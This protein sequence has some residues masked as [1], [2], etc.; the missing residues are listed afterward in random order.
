M[1]PVA[2]QQQ[3]QQHQQHQQHPGTRGHPRP[4][5]VTP[6]GQWIPPQQQGPAP[7]IFWGNGTP[8]QRGANG[9]FLQIPMILVPRGPTAPP[10]QAP[11]VVEAKTITNQANLQKSTLHLMRRRRK[12]Q[13]AVD[14]PLTGP[15]PSKKYKLAFEFDSTAATTVTVGVFCEERGLSKGRISLKPIHPRLT[16]TPFPPMEFAPGTGQ[17]V[18]PPP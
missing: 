13:G 8:Y 3:Q 9:T 18:F 17:K 14:E 15:S 6:S 10:P 12:G 4:P 16:M 5:H 7:Q 2:Q 11:D 1:Q